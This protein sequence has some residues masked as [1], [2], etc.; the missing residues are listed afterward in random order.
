[1]CEQFKRAP[2]AVGRGKA[3]LQERQ[4]KQDDCQ[5]ERAHETKERGPIRIPPAQRDQ[6]YREG[7][8]RKRTN[9]TA[10]TKPK[11]IRQAQRNDSFPH[12]IARLGV[13]AAMQY[14]SSQPDGVKW[15]EE[16]E[17]SQN[18]M[19][20]FLLAQQMDSTSARRH[21]VDEG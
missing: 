15:P 7:K 21:D 17:E 20:G 9:E 18:K 19:P 1:H 8:P 12:R 10:K 3:E 13:I 14:F 16:E 4:I 11:V 5:H 2:Q 6:R